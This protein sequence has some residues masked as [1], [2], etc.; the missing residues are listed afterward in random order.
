MKRLLFIILLLP[1]MAMAQGG[2]DIFAKF[3]L[4]SGFPLRGTS[5]VRG[6]E[7]NIIV[8]DLVASSTNNN[9]SVQLPMPSSGA[10]A[11]FT[12]YIQ[13]G[14]KLPFG[15]IIVTSM[16]E[17][18]RIIEYKIKME[19]I[20]VA[21]ATDNNGTTKL[22]LDAA[23]IGWIYYSTNNKGGSTVSSKTGWDKEKGVAWT[24][25]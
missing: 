12:S 5:T 1:V 10:T 8:T 7:K 14:K 6:Y 11:S 21:E 25:F 23:R 13:S 15:E 17:G 16:L 3:N 4:E 20:A 24:N 9:T 19:G 18:Q 22:V 2:K